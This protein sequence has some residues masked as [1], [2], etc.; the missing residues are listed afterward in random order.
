MVDTY[1]RLG[2]RVIQVTY[3]YA[4]LAGDG[5]LEERNAG[6]TAFGRRIVRRMQ[7]IGI[8]VDLAHAG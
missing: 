2:V 3:N 5:C 1:A 7:D 8:T 4:E 6:L